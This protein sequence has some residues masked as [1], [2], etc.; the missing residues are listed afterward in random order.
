MIYLLI[1]LALL[2]DFLNGFHDSSNVVATPI[3]SNAMRPRM[4]LVLAAAAHFAAPFIFGV[5]VPTTIGDELL[6]VDSL[7][8]GVINAAL[9]AAIVW[10][11][12]TWYFG[13]PSSSSH[14]LVGGL[15]G[16]AV[17]AEGIDAVNAAGL[18]R[19]LLALLISP[20]IGMAAGYLTMRLVLLAVRGSSPA[21]NTLF[22]RSQTVTLAGLALSHGTNDT[23]KTMGVI[24]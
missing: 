11:L 3:S 19:V 5:A 6:N 23:Q 7:G 24:T 1:A 17:V 10:N 18:T 21:V 14:A 20:P 4:A 2:F 12:A 8:V 15:L 9:A 22:R 13:I 16:A